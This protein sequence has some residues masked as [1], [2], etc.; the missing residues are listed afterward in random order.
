MVLALFP[1]NLKLVVK[2][3]RLQIAGILLMSLFVGKRTAVVFL[4]GLRMG[5]ILF[6]NIDFSGFLSGDESGE[7]WIWRN[8]GI[9]LLRYGKYVSYEAEEKIGI[10]F[11]INKIEYYLN[12]FYH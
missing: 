10:N 12:L 7:S 1:L 5:V 4:M 11:R 8:V 2:L 3:F 9:Y 6:A